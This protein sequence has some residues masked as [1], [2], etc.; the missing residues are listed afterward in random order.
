MG[1]EV[2]HYVLAIANRFLP[3]PAKRFVHVPLPDEYYSSL[4]RVVDRAQ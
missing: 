2:F 3:A 4:R 1:P